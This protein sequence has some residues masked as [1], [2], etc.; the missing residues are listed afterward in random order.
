MVGFLRGRCSKGGDI[1]V[2]FE[3]GWIEPAN[4]IEK[5]KY[6]LF[7]YWLGKRGRLSGSP[8]WREGQSN[9]GNQQDDDGR[10]KRREVEGN[11]LAGGHSAGECRGQ[12]INPNLEPVVEFPAGV[13][14]RFAE[15][16]VERMVVELRRK[17]FL[18]V[19]ERLSSLV[20]SIWR[21]R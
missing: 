21:A 1:I 3:S 15:E 18:L 6:L 11:Q 12:L 5:G 4:E 19:H 9:E 20:F 13:G 16:G 8:V 14:E 17:R 10:G 7:E 2:L